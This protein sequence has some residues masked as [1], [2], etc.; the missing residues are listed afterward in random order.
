MGVSKL[1]ARGASL[2]RDGTVLCCDVHVEFEAGQLVAIVGPNGAGK[3]SLLALLA[4]DLEPADGSVDLDG[5]SLG[6]VEPLE[7]ARRRA[8]LSQSNTVAFPFSVAEVVTMG[9]FPWSA[10]SSAATDQRIVAESMAATDVSHLARRR[11]TTLSGGEAARVA[12]A[13]VLA[14]DT[15]IVLLDEPTAS[16]DIKHQEMVFDLLRAKAK[17]GALVIIVVHDLEAAAAIADRLIVMNDGRVVADGR[18]DQILSSELLSDV[19][20]YPLTV[21]ADPVSG[22][23]EIR[24]RRNPPTGP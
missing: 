20:D 17:D 12:L 8:V 21:K 16:L 2:E 1:R 4:G 3:S 6:S 11:I 10:Q 9:R 23:L 18:P 22:S 13:R 15:S 14:Q 24:P 19:Y 7:L 5:A